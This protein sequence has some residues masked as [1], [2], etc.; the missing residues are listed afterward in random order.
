MKTSI[1][2]LLISILFVA[3]QRAPVELGLATDYLPSSE[4]LHQ[5]IVSKFYEHYVP[6]NKDKSPYT[7]ISYY[8]Y[9]F[10]YPDN[11]FI[12][13]F[14]AGMNL[15]WSTS[16]QIIDNQW[17]IN[18]LTYSRAGDT[19]KAEINQ[20]IDYDWKN[21]TSTAQFGLTFL[22][23]YRNNILINQ[24]GIM[25]TIVDDMSCKTIQK[26]N[27][28][29]TISPE[30]DT[31]YTSAFQSFV[32]APGM[33]LYAK[34]I[35]YKDLNIHYEL[36]EQMPL[37]EFQKRANHGKNRMA[38]IDP[39]N[40]MDDASNFKLCNTEARIGDYYN[41]ENRGQLR[42]GKGTWKRVLKKELIPEKLYNESGYLTYRFVIN[43][44]GEVGRF[45]TEESDLNFN[46]KKFNE[47]T[48]QHLYEIVYN[49]KD[50]QACT[51]G[52]IESQDA[53]TYIT[54][55]LKDGKIIEI[56]P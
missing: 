28:Y 22:S 51:G 35:E 10:Q 23:R 24:L 38:Y 6:K 16:Y 20:T 53:Y 29:T 18:E 3:C 42:G 52:R 5:G 7:D 13:K 15:N 33:G 44:N 12:E 47:E 49:Q 2:L 9:A 46:K 37:S 54:F 27:T 8:C 43:C 19:I 14:D 31:T 32:Y 11:L 4:N 25:D 39:N 55:K 26:K 41:C 34:Y 45:I 50:W 56:L 21:Q 36:V 40:T 1:L 30:N 48:V 17:I